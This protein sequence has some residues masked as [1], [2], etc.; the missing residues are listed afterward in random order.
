MSF[1]RGA[2]PDNECSEMISERSDMKK[3]YVLITPVHN[4]ERFIEQLIKSVIAQTVPPQNWIIVD[5]ASTDKTSE[6]IKRYAS[7]YNFITYFRGLREYKTTY[8]SRRTRVVLDG[9]EKIKSRKFDFL[10]VLDADITIDPTYY[11][12]ILHEFDRDPK[13]GIAAGIYLY[14]V[15]GHLQE[16]VMDQLCTPGSNHVFRR[17]CYEEIGG[18][19]P[20]KY[21]GDDSLADIMARMRGWKTWSFRQYAVIQRRSVGTRDRKSI[22]EARL[23]QGLMEYGVATQPLFM[24]AKS[25]RRV[26]LEKPYFIG[27]LARLAGFMYGYLLREKRQIP[28]EVIRY[29]RREQIRRLFSYI[30]NTNRTERS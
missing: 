29:V 22:L 24:L 1:Q 21:G 26:F 25:L 12:I 4:E 5:D 8:Y 3:D 28:P 20:L 2:R 15:D 11:E 9:Y 17:E 13:L 19:I 23:R 16:V 30:T 10:G 14:E 18:Y 27:S 7:L 6:I